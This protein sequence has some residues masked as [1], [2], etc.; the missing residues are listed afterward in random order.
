[1]KKIYCLLLFIIT[2]GKLQAADLSVTAL[3]SP[4]EPANRFC[5]YISQAMARL[6]KIQ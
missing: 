5:Y 4:V 3:V 1:M 6:E 2:P